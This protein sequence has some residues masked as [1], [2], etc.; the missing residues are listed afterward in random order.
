[1]SHTVGFDFSAVRV[2]TDGTAAAIS[3][4]LNARAFT[5]GKDV[6]FDRHEFNPRSFEGKRLLAHELTHVAQQTVLP[7]QAAGALQISR[8]AGPQIARQEKKPEGTEASESPRASAAPA[9]PQ[10][11]NSK[12]APAAA[13][14]I[15]PCKKTRVSGWIP[16]SGGK[17]ELFGLTTFSTRNVTRWPKL[18]FKKVPHGVTVSRTQASLAAV[19]MKSLEVGRYEE[20]TRKGKQQFQWPCDIDVDSWCVN[21]GKFFKPD[22]TWVVDASSATA[23]ESGE[24]E[25]CNDIH[26]AFGLTAGLITRH[27]NALADSGQI[28]PSE[29]DARAELKKTVAIDEAEWFPYFTC[30]MQKAVKERDGSGSHTPLPPTNRRLRKQMTLRGNAV[31]VPVVF[32]N[33]LKPWTLDVLL[34]A[35]A[36]KCWPVPKKPQGP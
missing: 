18:E 5:H 35:A 4:Q 12:Q 27:I 24:L 11:L 33:R 28:F 7:R 21:Q 32:P 15:A 25:H 20:Q 29:S 31:D 6:Y 3:R 14:S 23:L 16:D 19:E 26:A 10:P 22:V 30:L 13:V 8:A 17:G 2:H 36:P 34:H 9:A 1:M